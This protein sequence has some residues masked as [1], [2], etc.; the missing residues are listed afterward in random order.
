IAE[1]R[2]LA[3]LKEDDD[4]LDDSLDAAWA[5]KPEEEADD[6]HNAQEAKF[7]RHDQ[8]GR[9]GEA[10]ERMVRIVH[11]EWWDY[12]AAPRVWDP[13]AGKLVSLQPDQV[14][15]LQEAYLAL[16]EPFRV[17]QQ[18]K[19]VYNKAILGGI[20]L[21]KVERGNE[22]GG[23]SH[24]A[25]TGKRD[26][27]R[28]CFYGLVRAMHDPQMWLNKWLTQTLHLLNSTS[29]GGI[30]AEPTAFRDQNQA[31]DSIASADA[32][33]WVNEGAIRD[34]RITPKP[35]TQL[36]A[37]LPQLIQ[38]AMGAFPSVTGVSP[39]MMGAADRDQAGVLEM[40]RKQQGM[41]LLADFFSNFRRYRK[42]QGRLLV[43][44]LTEFLSDGRL[45][46]IGGSENARYIPFIRRPDLVEYDILVDDTPTSPNMKER[47]WGML[48]QLFPLLQKLNLPP[49]IMVE[50]LKFSPLPDTLTAKIEQMIQ[51]MPMP[52]MAQMQRV[53]AQT[54]LDQAKAADMQARGAHSQAEAQRG[55]AT[56]GLEMQEKQAQIEL[57]RAQAIAALEKTGVDRDQNAL[58]AAELAIDSLLQAHAQLNAPPQT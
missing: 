31:E 19:K 47:T 54:A 32:I 18:R 36:P 45:V 1:G 17:V 21:S 57:L 23:F 58:Q 11:A 29:K 20:M 7:Y 22:K 25:I 53:Q 38:W 46:R 30:Y 33:T 44:L 28:R 15:P 5:H 27:K 26:D 41:V 9:L 39:E 55:Q 24:K 34:E 12:E 6:P 10:G 40:Q 13:K 37:A 52:G 2:I 4:S 43:W 51:K 3:G 49:Q 14:K 50:L 35:V 56:L 48:I 42:E 8:S 16:G